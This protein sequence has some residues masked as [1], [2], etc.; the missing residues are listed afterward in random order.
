MATMF[1]TR[2]GHWRAQVRRKGKYVSN[3]FRLKTQAHEWLR[4]VEHLIDMG[5]S[6]R[7]NPGVKYVP[8]VPW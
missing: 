4:D 6:P 5:V 7:N 3:T 2:Q 8:S 1:K